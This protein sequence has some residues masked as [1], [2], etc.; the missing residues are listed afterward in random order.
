MKT[1][2]ANDHANLRRQKDMAILLRA[3][4]ARA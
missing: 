4:G 3:N 2:K 1:S